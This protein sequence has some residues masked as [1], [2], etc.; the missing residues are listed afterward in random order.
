MEKRRI[1]FPHFFREMDSKFNFI[2]ILKKVNETTPKI[3]IRFKPQNK[4]LK[5]QLNT[6]I[7]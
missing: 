7:R 1:F 4:D 6:L 2:N 5:S 3:S